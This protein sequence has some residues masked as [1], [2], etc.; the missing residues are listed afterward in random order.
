M[1]RGRDCGP[2]SMV[3]DKGHLVKWPVKGSPWIYR[4]HRTGLYRKLLSAL[5]NFTCLTPNKHVLPNNDHVL[6]IYHLV[7]KLSLTMTFYPE[8]EAGRQ[9]AAPSCVSQSAHCT[10]LPTAEHHQLQTAPEGGR[11][12]FSTPGLTVPSSR[13]ETT[14][15][16]WCIAQ[17]K[18][19]H[20]LPQGETP[21]S[22]KSPFCQI[23]GILPSILAP[24][25]WGTPQGSV[26]KP[27]T[28][29]GL[30]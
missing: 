16:G 9:P 15:F 8:P 13:K 20:R 24:E 23:L 21:I 4:A 7:R 18:G 11:A 2:F 1:E 26:L 12:G 28:K 17:R 14:S 22:L 3:G 6:V 29:P 10:L 19:T 5:G 27:H 30:S 25:P